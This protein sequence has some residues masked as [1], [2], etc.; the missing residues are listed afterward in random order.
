MAPKNT[1]N[2]A[3]GNVQVKQVAA[4]AP[5]TPLEQPNL[6][7]QQDPSVRNLSTVIVPIQMQRIRQ[8]TL[9]WRD[10]INEMEYAYY[11]YRVKCQQM[12][13]DTQLNGHV[14]ACVSRRKD[15]TLLRKGEFLN[16]AGT[17]DQKTADIF[18]T[19]V[20]GR[21]QIKQWYS[22]FISNALD[23]VFYGYTLEAMGDVIENGFPN[24]NSIRRWNISPDR[25]QVTTF[26]YQP[27]G[28]KFDDDQYADWH[29]FITTPNELGNS[30]CGYG[31]FYK[32]ALYE[33]FLRNLFGY[34]GDFVEMYAQPYRVGKTT[35]TDEDE[36]AEFA[37]AIQQM[38][39]NGW[40]LIDPQDQIE[41][42]ETALG[43]TGYKAYDNFESRLNKIISK[44]LLGHADAM[45]STPGKLGSDKGEES[46]AQSAMEDKQTTDGVFIENVVNDLLLPKMRRLGFMIPEDVRWVYKNDAEIMQTADKLAVIGTKMVA[47]G[48]QMTAEHYTQETGIPCT[49]AVKAAPPIAPSAKPPVQQKETDD[50]TAKVA[51]KLQALYSDIHAHRHTRK[52]KIA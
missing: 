31:L 10:A 52:E 11:P 29:V 44:V 3:P 9:T 17:I 7:P 45:D 16:S 20:K 5:T 49:L 26:P 35:K 42:L 47:A 36:R 1:G 21:S 51:K 40:A 43:G 38:G 30:N 19:E 2:T 4:P 13:S 27:N 25:R 32:V 12:F 8:S 15:L 14:T 50:N 34:N 46:P 48:L 18:T 37:N 41:F 22:L 23:A 24:L 33:I 6:L 28:Y 39:A